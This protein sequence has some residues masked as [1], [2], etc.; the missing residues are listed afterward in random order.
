MQIRAQAIVEGQPVVGTTCWDRLWSSGLVGKELDQLS[1][2]MLDIL[3][4]AMDRW[5]NTEV[6]E[7]GSGTGRISLSLRPLGARVTLVDKSDDA[8]GLAKQFSRGGNTSFIR[9]D[10]L[11]L[12]FAKESFDLTWN[13][14]VL[15]HLNDED[16]EIAVA[17]MSRVTKRTGLLVAFCPNRKCLPYRIGK[18]ILER[19]GKW[20]YGYEEP[21]TSLVDQFSRHGVNLV[22]EYDLGI[23]R[24]FTFLPGGSSKRILR[25]LSRIEPFLRFM[26]I[27]GYLVVS[28]GRRS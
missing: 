23:V 15:E 5:Q 11:C 26:R 12:P 2:Q 20:P 8:L 27:P 24:G 3:S 16:L 1:L 7:A 10:L 9:G 28:I 4:N 21:I 14:G 13:G 6:L 22:S 19:R 25:A 17:E 18:A